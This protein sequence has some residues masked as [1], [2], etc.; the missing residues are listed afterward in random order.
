MDAAIVEIQQAPARV[1]LRDRQGVVIGVIERQ[2]LVGKLIARDA[3]VGAYEERS[4]ITRDR[5]GRLVGRTNLL[6][7]LLFRE[8]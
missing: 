2:P 8:R 5:H 7:A 3:R 1:V 6:Q 4:R